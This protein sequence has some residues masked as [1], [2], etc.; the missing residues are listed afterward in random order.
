MHRRGAPRSGRM[1]A[2]RP[3]GD[4]RPSIEQ[5]RLSCSWAATKG[6]RRSV[7]SQAPP[8]LRQRKPYLTGSPPSR[9]KRRYRPDVECP[10]YNSGMKR[11]KGVFRVTLGWRARTSPPRC[12]G[13]SSNGVRGGTDDVDHEVGIGEHE[14]VAAGDLIGSEVRAGRALLGK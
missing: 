12:C 5:S 14:D 10:E 13:S 9:R 7:S 2:N 8:L 6:E 1:V 4:L 3:R 11:E